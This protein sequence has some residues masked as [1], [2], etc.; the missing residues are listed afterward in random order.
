[1][2]LGLGAHKAFVSVG[3]VQRSLLGRSAVRPH[4]LP[5]LQASVESTRI[6]LVAVD[7]SSTAFAVA[8]GAIALPLLL[9]VLLLVVVVVPA[10]ASTIS[11]VLTTLASPVAIL[12]ARPVPTNES[13]EIGNIVG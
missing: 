1:M 10:F 2:V 7:S 11:T 4:A 9:M 5:F 3:V 6:A 8:L 12:V 13:S